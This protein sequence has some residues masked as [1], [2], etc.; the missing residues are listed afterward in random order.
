MPDQPN[1]FWSRAIRFV[2][3]ALFG[4]FLALGYFLYYSDTSLFHGLGLLGGLGMVLLC[5]LASA[6]VGDDFWENLPIRGWWW[7]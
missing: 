6:A 1:D 3:G 5:G 7:W 4:A 2:F